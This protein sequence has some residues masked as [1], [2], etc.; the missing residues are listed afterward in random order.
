M[1]KNNLSMAFLSSSFIFAVLFL[2]PDV[3]FA[4]AAEV[5]QTDSGK[6]WIGL[7]YISAALAVGLACLGSAFA[8][9]RIGSAGLGAISE[10][11]ELT[12][13]VL[14]FLGLAEGIAI[15]GLIVAIMILNKL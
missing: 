7:A 6:D 3:M 10:K 9:A 13:R 15:Y 14:V 1:T 2:F 5:G 4:A 12:G 11:P 8:V